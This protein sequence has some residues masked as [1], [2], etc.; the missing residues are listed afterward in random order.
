VSGRSVKRMTFFAP[1]WLV[2]MR[3]GQPTLSE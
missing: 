3:F 2:L 1:P